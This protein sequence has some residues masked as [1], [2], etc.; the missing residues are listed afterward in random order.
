MRFLIQEPWLFL[1]IGVPTGTFGFI[2]GSYQDDTALLL[3]SVVLWVVSFAAFAVSSLMRQTREATLRAIE[4]ERRDSE[5]RKRIVALAEKLGRTTISSYGLPLEH[6]QVGLQW[7]TL[8]G[9]VLEHYGDEGS[10]FYKR[11]REAY[12]HG[13]YDEYE[14]RTGMN[15]EDVAAYVE[16]HATD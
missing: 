4:T 1:T 6:Y 8:L 2:T 14:Q 11:V 3:A 9:L 13:L 5:N 7:G 16:E 10:S 15:R 12:S